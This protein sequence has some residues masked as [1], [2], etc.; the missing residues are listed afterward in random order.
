MYVHLTPD[1]EQFVQDNVQSG[2]YSSAS[3]VIGDA[4]RLLGQNDELRDLQ[5][6]E[7]RS[8]IDIGLSEASRGEDGEVFM[9]G[10]IEDLDTEPDR[11]AG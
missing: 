3:E 9:R 5:L 7:L 1:L 8:R 11:K 2:R 6:Q 4:L 10:L